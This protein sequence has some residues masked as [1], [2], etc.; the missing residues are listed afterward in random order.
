MTAVRLIPAVEPTTS[1]TYPIS[2]EYIGRWTAERAIAEIIA[3]AIDADPS[4]FRVSYADGVCE[5]IDNASQGVGSEGMVLGFSDKRGR[6]DQI[7]QFGEGLKIATLVLARDKKIG[8]VF[9]ETVGYAFTPA[10]IEQGAISGLS[11]PNKTGKA[12]QVLSWRIYPCE[13]STGTRVRIVCDE[14]TAAAAMG[15]FRHLSERN[16]KVDPE[17]G[18]VI[19]DGKPGRVFIGGV[20]VSERKDLTFSYDLPL[21]RTKS[22]QNRDRSVIDGYALKS[23]INDVL[24][25]CNDRATLT[26][27]VE[28]ALEGKLSE[29][30]AGFF[31]AVQSAEQKRLMATIGKKL[32]TGKSVFWTDYGQE[33]AALDLADSKYVMLRVEGLNHWNKAS[34]MKLL[35][36]PSAN[37][38]QKKRAEKKQE[39]AEWVADRNLTESERNVLAESIAV[40]R[41]V[42]GA[43]AI[44][45]VRVYTRINIVGGGGECHSTLGFYEPGSGKIAVRRDGLADPENLLHTLTH[46]AGHRLAHREPTMVG[47]RYPDYNDRSRGFETALGFMAM[48]AARLVSQN[49]PLEQAAGHAAAASAAA[50][51]KA[52]DPATFGYKPIP[53]FSYKHRGGSWFVRV[54]DVGVSAGALVEGAIRAWAQREGVKPRSAVAAYAREHFVSSGALRNIVSGCVGA[55]YVRVR[56]VCEPLG[57][58]A[59][60]VWWAACGVEKTYNQQ[61][62][63]GPKRFPASVRAGAEPALAALEAAGG[64]FTDEVALLRGMLNGDKMDVTNADWITPVKRLVEAE[65]LRLDLSPTSDAS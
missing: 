15:R 9:V 64:V 20:F 28:R 42:W 56:E 39:K 52:I 49:V 16:Y 37:S 11:I 63:K 50:K 26:E 61:T 34:L 31:A 51:A 7:G 13:R 44:D 21:A 41:A 22:L 32:F 30:E 47:L 55:D 4:G 18:E 17:R 5:I 58:N 36:V 2:P 3:N 27:L 33:E 12:P 60:V 14:K 8:D 19:T 6:T 24:I 43:N 25:R 53:G 57:I 54:A 46:E 38:L 45:K 65:A 29:N 10:I 40:V 48:R 23:A 1:L 35:Q 59:G 62:R